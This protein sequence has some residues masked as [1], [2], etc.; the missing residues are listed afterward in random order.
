LNQ[1]LTTEHLGRSFGEPEVGTT[2]IAKSTGRGKY[3]IHAVEEITG[4]PAATLRAWERRYGVPVPARTSSAYRVYSDDDIAIIRRMVELCESGIAPSEAARVALDERIESDPA[5]PQANEDAFAPLREQ[6]LRAV[7]AFDPRG[8]EREL[9]R[10]AASAPAATIVDEVLRPV[11]LEVGERWHAGTITVAQEHLAS[12]AIG[13]ILRRMIT[14]A[15]PEGDARQVVLAG[16][17]DEEHAFPLQMLAVHLATWGYRAVLLG[18]RTPPAA[19]RQAVDELA[20]VLVCLSCTLAPSPHRARE[21]VDA[22]A[23]AVGETPWMV[24]GA[25]AVGLQR[26]V[27]ARGGTV[28]MPEPTRNLRPSIDRL[29]ARRRPSH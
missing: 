25:A 17:A 26:F 16:F 23:D 19:V 7:E 24:G 9:E 2:S 1:P 11:L 22:Y 14:L 27:E 18:T 15:Q 6:L 29:A 20:P 12:E 4:V 28:A 5:P 10:A 21:L 8:L 13:T 3:R